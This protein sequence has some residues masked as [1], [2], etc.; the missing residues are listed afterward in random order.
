MD[1]L[2]SAVA[3][4]I[5]KGPSFGYAFGDKVDLDQSIWTLHNGTK[6]EDG[7]KCSI[8][9]FDVNANKSCLPL[10]KNALRKF[11]TLRHPGIIKVLDTVETDAYIYIATERITPLSW[12]T[13][14]KSLSEESIKW[15]LH[16]I[17]RTLQ[18]IN[19]EASSVHGSVRTTSVFT[20]ESGE[21]KLG[22]LD[23]LSSMKEDDAIIYSYG[24]V[25]PDSGRYSPPEVAKGGWD[26]IKRN[27]LPAVDAY[28]YAILVSEV[29][30]G[31]YSG[32]D[33]AGQTKGVPHSMQASYKRLAHAN[34]KTRLSVSHF[35][36]QGK[37]SGAFFDTPLIQL[38]E[39]IDNLGLK[40]EAEREELL[41]ELDSVA[42]SDDFPEEFF[43]VKVL[44]ELLKSV[45]FGGGGPKVFALVMRISKKLPEDEYD[46]KITP[47][48]VRLFN[49]PD[50]A[51][52]VSLLDNLPLM[53]D[54]LNQKIVNDK[55]FPQMV[56]GFTD[57][58]PIVREQT[59]KAVLVV[60]GKLS[61]RTING[62]LLRCLAKTANDEQPG[63][64]TNTTIC[65]G[66]IARNLGVNSR[67]KVLT[68]AFTRSLRDP[69]VHARN[70]SLMALAATVELY[71]EE[72]C[73]GRLL[74]AIC[75]SLIDKEKI[76]RDQANKALDV[77]LQRIRKYGQ[78][79]PDSVAPPP[80]VAA[81]NA[82]PRMGT[83][84][85][86]NSWTG[87]AISSFTNKVAGASGEIQKKDAEP[88][89]TAQERPSSVP[90]SAQGALPSRIRPTPVPLQSAPTVPRVS[91]QLSNVHQPEVE[92]EE[93][94]G[95]W[96]DDNNNDDNEDAADVWGDF[97]DTPKHAAATSTSTT[98]FDDQ[99]EPDFAGWLDAQAK[100]KSQ[101]KKPLPKGLTSNKS[102]ARTS[103]QTG[104]TSSMAA[105]SIAPRKAKPLSTARTQA[106]PVQPKKV[107][108]EADDDDD[109]GD[110][111]G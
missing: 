44:P 55:I 2:K 74:P 80:G 85:N 53:I 88:G 97:D 42:D 25:I 60:I 48:I 13:K 100:A 75:P 110:A 1:F 86:D 47:V 102:S 17:A 4:A 77:F 32:A 107:D 98:A 81:A 62:E 79:M 99:G 36:E 50:R 73:A 91:S 66:K 84:Q 54:H 46:A 26:V 76:V 49:S 101:I 23:V 94:A 30:N 72:D 108:T 68:A 111:W 63:I 3:S 41:Q 67:T 8:F 70:A 57:L 89:N 19:E 90:P 27:P 22:G 87:W 51:M 61:D 106:Q 21:W 5:S 37:R 28:S 56:T 10:A 39:G 83:P 6:R 64:R 15:G 45:E 40:S 20:T 34:P 92:A 29:F 14:R 95:N 96:G 103:P 59:V 104:A 35:F 11:R 16:N 43:Q 82:P 9:S 78:S 71:T 33:Q 38:T 69:F 93:F 109:W 24:N 105:K 31:T 18:F 12:K 7:S 65:L 58:A 52:R